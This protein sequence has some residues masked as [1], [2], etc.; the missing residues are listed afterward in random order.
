MPSTTNTLDVRAIRADFPILERQVHGKRLI[1]LDSAASSQKP[2]QVI[3]AMDECIGAAT[4]MSIAASRAQRRSDGPVRAARKS[5]SL[6]WKQI[7][8]RGH[9]DTQC[10]NHQPRSYSWG[11][12]N[13]REGVRSS[14]PNGH[15]ANFVPWR[16]LQEKPAALSYQR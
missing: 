7:L 10:A 6:Y 3:D 12:A 4:P 11:R 16:C 14:P 8:A 9:L 2:R 5:G 13:I 15:H 1:F